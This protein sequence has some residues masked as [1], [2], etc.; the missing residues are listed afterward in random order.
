MQYDCVCVLKKNVEGLKIQE[1][2]CFNARKDINL[3][4]TFPDM[5]S[6]SMYVMICHSRMNTV[7]VQTPKVHKYNPDTVYI[8][9][10]IPR[11]I[12]RET[13]QTW[14]RLTLSRHS[15]HSKSSTLAEKPQIL[16]L[17]H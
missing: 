8:N 9:L 12:R 14:T 3:S 4:T 1:V 5:L 13:I 17:H 2:I 15:L 7:I 10:Q 16:I 11:G 6:D